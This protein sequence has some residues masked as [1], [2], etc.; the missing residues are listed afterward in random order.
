[1]LAHGGYKKL[2]SYQTSAII[3]DLTVEFCN[4][5]MTYKTYMSNKSYRTYDQMVQAARSGKQNIAEGSQAA[6]TSRK[7]EL[8]LLGVA[9]ASL[10]ELLADYEDFLRQNR[11]KLWDKDSDASQ[12][13]RGLAYM[14]NRTYETYMTYMTNAEAAANCLICLINQACYL[15][16]RQRRSLEAAFAKSGGYSEQ[17]LQSR[18]RARKIGHI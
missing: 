14:T 17:L 9:R 10:A 6:G 4:R 11:M 13:V 1:M 7:T 5:Y 18:L 12:A 16:D 2:A 3:Y 8:K 15:L